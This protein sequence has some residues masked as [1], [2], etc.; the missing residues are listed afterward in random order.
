MKRAAQVGSPAAVHVHV[1][2]EAMQAVLQA[3]IQRGSVGRWLGGAEKQN[4]TRT[5]WVSTGGKGLELKI[6]FTNATSTRSTSRY[7]P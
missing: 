7:R 1:E 5:Q 2:L 3:V 4:K 6:L